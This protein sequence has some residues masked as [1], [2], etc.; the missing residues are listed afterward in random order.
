MVNKAGG[1]ITRTE[2]GVQLFLCIHRP[3][4]ND[5]SFPKGHI[6]PGEKVET[7]ALREVLEETGLQCEIVRALPD[8]IYT[9]PHGAPSR[10]AMFEMRVV[11]QRPEAKDT[12]ADELRWCT[13]EEC[14]VLLS[15]DTVRNFFSAL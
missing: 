6:E 5:W 2:N 9:L 12:E 13:F 15:Y 7:A 11:A 4:Y 10:V 1:I 3:R 8:M 14:M